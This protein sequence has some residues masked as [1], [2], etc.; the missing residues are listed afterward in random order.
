MK[1]VIINLFAGLILLVAGCTENIVTVEQPTKE[2]AGKTISVN[3]V[4]PGENTKTRMAFVPNELDVNLRWEENDQILL[5][6]DDGI[7][8]IQQTVTIGAI[9]NNGRTAAFEVIVPEEIINGESETFNL[10]GMYGGVTFSAIDGEES[11]VVLSTDPWS[12]LFLQLQGRENVL[13]RFSE[14]N[15]D[16]NSPDISVSFQH[17]GSLFKIY[18]ENTGTTDLEGITGVELFS[19]TP[20]FAHQNADPEV[21]AKYDLISGTFV[22]GTTFSNVL[23]FPYSGD[24]LDG[25]VL[26]LWGWYPPSQ[27]A[28]DIW[29]A[30]NLRVRYGTGQ[31]YVTTVPKPA[32]T[33]TTDIGKAYHFFARFNSE[34]D[35][36]LAF[37]D[38]VYGVLMDERDDQIYSTVRIGS[39]TWMAENLRYFPGFPDEPE[40]LNLVTDGSVTEPRYYI[41]GYDRTPESLAAASENFVNY[42]V[43]YNWPAA[44]AGATSSSSNPSGVQGVCPDGWHLPSE[45]EWVQLTTFVGA[46][47]ASKLKETGTDFW[48]ES[49]GVTNEY[50]FSARGGGSRQPISSVPAGFYNLRINGHWMTSTQAT[51]TD[52]RAAWM[53]ANSSTGGYQTASKEYGGSVRCVKD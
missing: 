22:N 46:N 29:P 5:V 31:E 20:I 25:D 9:T 11:Y 4:M 13:I 33:T 10:Y 48:N 7:N 41:Y 3:A 37:S 45:A 14:M 43:L 6:F 15:I 32:R 12:G 19:E 50:G 47:A 38:I 16:K 2:I 26:Q 21:G 42:G 24:L 28:G 39:Q 17:V 52:M 27:V 40:R 34:L 18:L 53:Q 1:K 35:P 8:K 51:E 36:A 44:M 23:P 30:I 49:I